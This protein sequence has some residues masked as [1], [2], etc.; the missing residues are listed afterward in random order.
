VEPGK[1][2]FFL[3]SDDGS[4]LF[5]DDNLAVDN[6]GNHSELT[7]AGTVQLEAGVHAVR[8]EYFDRLGGAMIRL[9]W[10][11]EHLERRLIGAAD[12]R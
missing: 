3:T 9:E 2:S 6:W 4:R 7:M 5:V 11:S 12:L 8:V 1:Y 10:S